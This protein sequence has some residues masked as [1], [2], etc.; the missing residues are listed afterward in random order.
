MNQREL[1]KSLLR[2]ALCVL[3]KFLCR[4][5]K[6]HTVIIH[7]LQ[8]FVEFFK[9]PNN[10]NLERLIQMKNATSMLGDNNKYINCNFIFRGA[11]KKKFN[12]VVEVDRGL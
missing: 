7:F 11:E 3:T 10:N 5:L 6:I 8:K 4:L 1:R 12:Y 2:C 9:I